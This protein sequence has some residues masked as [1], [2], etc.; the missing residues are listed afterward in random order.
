MIS[1]EK[2]V[3]LCSLFPA[4]MHESDWKNTYEPIRPSIHIIQLTKREAREKVLM[5]F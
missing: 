2:S 5:A 3:I 1:K 4:K